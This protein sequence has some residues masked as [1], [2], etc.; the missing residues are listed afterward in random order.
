MPIYLV[1]VIKGVPPLERLRQA[2]KTYST[3]GALLYCASAS[4]KALVKSIRTPGR[5]EA[6]SPKA[7]D[8]PK[9]V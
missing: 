1:P 3:R 4:P 5:V 6:R 8:H 9:E 2:L 7:K